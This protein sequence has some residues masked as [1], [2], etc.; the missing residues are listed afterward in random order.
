MRTLAQKRADYAL[1]IYLSY[2]HEANFKHEDFKSF[3]AGAPSVI[4]QN[5]FG[6]AMAFWAAKE[7]DNQ[8]V[9]SKY[10]ILFKMVQD[11]LSLKEDDIQN[12][13]L[14]A[15][16]SKSSFF[17]ALVKLNQNQYLTAQ[18]ETLAFLEWVK[19]FANSNLEA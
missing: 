17:Q 11:W 15:T 3:A 8:L 9:F 13:F 19:R 1:N 18:K 5:G 16:H 10:R 6:Q 14:P 2:A 12:D 4:L 7:N